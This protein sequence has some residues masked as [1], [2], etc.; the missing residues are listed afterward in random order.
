MLQGIIIFGAN[1]MGAAAL[2][3]TSDERTRQTFGFME[4]YEPAL[5]GRIHLIRIIGF[6]VF[7]LF[8][9]IAAELLMNPATAGQGFTSGL[10]WSYLLSKT[11]NAVMK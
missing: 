5:L 4:L 1:L 8:G 2:W 3:A 10:A 7:V 11:T 6:L 9:G